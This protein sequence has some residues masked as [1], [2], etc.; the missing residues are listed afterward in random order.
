MPRLHVIGVALCEMIAMR[1]LPEQSA[2]WVG[3]AL[4]Y[5]FFWSC[6]YEITFLALKENL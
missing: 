5:S 4:S 6:S 3:I 1:F 2:S